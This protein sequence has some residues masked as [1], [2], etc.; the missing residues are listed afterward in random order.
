M[1]NFFFQKKTKQNKNTEKLKQTAFL[2]QQ[3]DENDYIRVE[4]FDH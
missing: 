4:K 3:D 2:S 1:L